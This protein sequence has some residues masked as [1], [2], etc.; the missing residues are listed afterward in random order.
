MHI[1]LLA[2]IVLPFIGLALPLMVWYKKRNT[3]EYT[4]AQGL[5]V[6]NFLI[7]VFVIGLGTVLLCVLIIGILLVVPIIIFAFV[8][9]VIAA[10]KCS[11]GKNFKY[12]LI[13]RFIK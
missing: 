10:I 2:G 12:P 9:P 13:Y 7:N 11:R 1:S 3:S 6:I 8:M 4:K 5:E